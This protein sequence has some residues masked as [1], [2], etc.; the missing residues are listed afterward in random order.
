MS[1]GGGAGTH[2]SLWVGV[3]APVDGHH[4]R[5]GIVFDRELEDRGGAVGFEPSDGNSRNVAFAP[6]ST[7][8]SRDERECAQRKKEFHAISMSASDVPGR[9]LEAG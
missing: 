8:G 4:H 7:A 3:V 5:P 6:R 1:G 2:E 9:L